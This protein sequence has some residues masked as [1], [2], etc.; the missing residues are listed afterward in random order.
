MQQLQFVDP[1]TLHPAY[2]WIRGDRN[3][4]KCDDEPWLY[5]TMFEAENFFLCYTNS[6]MLLYLIYDWI[7]KISRVIN[8]WVNY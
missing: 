4:L 2:F 1:F 8:V 6:F 7:I 3:K 5:K